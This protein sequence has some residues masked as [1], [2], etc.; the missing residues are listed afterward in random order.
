MCFF[1][2]CSYATPIVRAYLLIYSKVQVCIVHWEVYPGYWMFTV[3]TCPLTAL[4]WN[5][6][7]LTVHGLHYLV[8]LFCTHLIKEVNPYTLDM[9]FSPLKTT[10][11]WGLHPKDICM[12]YKPLRL[13]QCKAPSVLLLRRWRYRLPNHIPRGWWNSY[14]VHTSLG[15][16]KPQ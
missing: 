4:H 15:L 7:K 16:R 11:N 2:Q 9:I 12:L 3:K 13:K 10:I 6:S 5:H 8:H 14:T 1:Q